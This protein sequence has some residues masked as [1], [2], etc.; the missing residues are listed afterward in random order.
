[1][2]EVEPEDWNRRWRGQWRHVHADESDVLVG[3]VGGRSPGRALDLA[4]GEGRNAVWL[5]ER[6]WRVTGVDFS[7][8]ALAEARRRARERAVEV[9]WV[10]ADVR[11][12]DPGAGTFDLVLVFFLHL[13]PHE[14]RSLL[15][16][17]AAA[18]A[19]GG[20][21]LV[22]GHDLA[23][24][25]TDAYGP[26]DPAVLYVPEKIARELPGLAIEKAE[27]VT[28]TVRTE[29]GEATAVDAL[30]RASRPAPG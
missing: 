14:R 23:N 28:R 8:V 13:R 26:S 27:S 15:T 2:P 10:E 20:T 16:R 1:M 22:A 11:D 3:E 18:V 25:R 24:L 29:H 4:C 7:E 21:L 30:V 5:A 19:E 6:G 9:E 17:A 12:Y